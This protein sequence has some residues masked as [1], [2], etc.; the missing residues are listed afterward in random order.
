MDR[1]GHVRTP[2]FARRT[3]PFAWD[4]TPQVIL[5]SAVTVVVVTVVLVI[6]TTFAGVGLTKVMPF[7]DSVV[8]L[9]WFFTAQVE[10]E[11][12]KICDSSAMT[13]KE[14]AEQEV[15]TGYKISTGTRRL[16][17]VEYT[18]TSGVQLH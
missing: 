12:L 9:T 2:T 8:F 13:W 17:C 10:D 1:S 18:A 11:P 15:L 14:G 16:E 6:A 5:P 7:K 4:H 3:A